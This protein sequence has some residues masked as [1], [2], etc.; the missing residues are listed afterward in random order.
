MRVG[1]RNYIAVA[2]Q[3]HVMVCII[4]KA[5]RPEN[6]MVLVLAYILTSLLC[7]WSKYT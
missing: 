4:R 5:A 3:E 6:D 2:S 7:E 1:N